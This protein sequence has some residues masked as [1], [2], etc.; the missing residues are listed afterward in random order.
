MEDWVSKNVEHIGIFFGYVPLTREKYAPPTEENLDLNRLRVD[1]SF[2]ERGS[3]VRP[4]ILR[5]KELH[6]EEFE[7]GK[8]ANQPIRKDE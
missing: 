4:Q 3:W 8:N 2:F 5:Y 1:M 7:E 6:P